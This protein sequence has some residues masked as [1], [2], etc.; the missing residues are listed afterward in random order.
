LWR[1]KTVRF[2]A[3]AIAVA[4]LTYAAGLP[5]MEVYSGLIIAIVGIGNTILRTRT[6]RPA[7]FTGGE[8][9]EVQRLARGPR[10]L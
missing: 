8:M 9:V 7:T 3:L 10:S 1:S 5:D 4:A 6:D 2:N